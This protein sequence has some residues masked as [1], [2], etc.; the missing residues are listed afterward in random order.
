[1]KGKRGRRRRGG[2]GG[3]EKTHSDVLGTVRKPGAH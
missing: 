1:V 2:G 3:G